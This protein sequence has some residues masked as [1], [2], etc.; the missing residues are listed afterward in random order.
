MDERGKCGRGGEASVLVVE[1][2]RGVKRMLW[3]SLRSAGFRVVEASTGAEALRILDRH[4]PDAVVLDL[5]LPDGR[6]PDV[7][8]R[9]NRPG[10]WAGKEPV[11]TV[12]SAL[13]RGEARRRYG[14]MSDRFISKPFDPWDLIKALEE[15]LARKAGRAQPNR[16]PAGI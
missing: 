5:G 10:D 2:D 4:P 3:F 7:L 6:G 13:D 15:L 9:L 11:W 14:P 12:I 1:D 8:D 16:G